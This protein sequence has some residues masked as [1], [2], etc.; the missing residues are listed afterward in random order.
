MIEIYSR[1]NASNL[2]P[3][4]WTVGELDI[5]YRRHAVGGSFEGTREPGYL[6]M[7]PNARIP[8][9]RDG[10]LVLWESNA[11]VRHLCRTHDATGVLLPETEATYALSDQW[12]DWH[13]TTLYPAYI[14][15]AWA[16]VRTEPAVRDHDRIARCK[17]E[18]EAAL[19]ILDSHLATSAFVVGDRLGMADMPFGPLYYRYHYLNIERPAFP[20]IERWYE[21]FSDRPAFVEHVAFPFGENPGQWYRIERELG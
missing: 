21:S 15:L 1:R 12:M 9:I 8:T 4:M 5:P 17:A 18:T 14:E 7:N 11:I 6:A 3:V 13:K 20:N 10:D 2:L 19:A 16:I